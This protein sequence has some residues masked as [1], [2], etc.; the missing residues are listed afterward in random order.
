MRDILFRGKT[1]STD[2]WIYGGYY[3]LGDR[4]FIAT[5]VDFETNWNIDTQTYKGYRM[6]EV[7]PNSVGQSIGIKDSNGVEI[8]EGDLIDASVDGVAKVRWNKRACCFEY[9]FEG[10]DEPEFIDRYEYYELDI[11]GNIYDKPKWYDNYVYQ[12]RN[13]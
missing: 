11:V 5:E 9:M 8:Y 12:R 1:I 2:K 6:I 4:T 10:I 3:K 13:E 7:H